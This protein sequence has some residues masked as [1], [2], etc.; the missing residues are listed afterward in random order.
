MP[1]RERIARSHPKY[2]IRKVRKEAQKWTMEIGNITDT[3]VVITKNRTCL[4]E[5]KTRVRKYDKLYIGQ[6]DLR[7]NNVMDLILEDYIHFIS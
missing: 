6:D 5:Q 7:G 1:E 2:R 4:P 3:C